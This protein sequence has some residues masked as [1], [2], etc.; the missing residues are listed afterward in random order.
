MVNLNNFI[1]KYESKYKT[2]DCQILALLSRPQSAN[3]ILYQNYTWKHI[4]CDLER[5]QE[6][7]NLRCQF[8]SPVLL[9]KELVFAMYKLSNNLI[10]R[11]I[12][13]PVVCSNYCSPGV[14]TQQADLYILTESVC[15]LDS[16]LPNNCAS[17]LKLNIFLRVN[18]NAQIAW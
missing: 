16:V 11:E 15:H 3:N 18:W 13:P 2:V 4:R 12:K 5:L 9:L 7:R 1:V 6:V 14:I 8:V 17:N 10:A